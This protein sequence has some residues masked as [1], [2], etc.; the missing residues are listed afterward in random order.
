MPMKTVAIH[1]DKRVR[2]TH[3]QQLAH[4]RNFFQTLQPSKWGQGAVNYTAHD[5][6]M[7]QRSKSK[8]EE[9]LR[10]QVRLRQR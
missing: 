1:P 2:L 10:N 4:V 5:R 7:A 6:A 3:T 9:N 8:H